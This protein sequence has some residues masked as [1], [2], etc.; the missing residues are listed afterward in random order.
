[1]E[2]NK[3]DFKTVYD[4]FHLYKSLRYRFDRM[5]L[6]LNGF[7]RDKEFII[8]G[9]MKESLKDECLYIGLFYS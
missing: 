3:I 1:M 7:L 5:R 2:L 4:C 6:V 9:I 8:N